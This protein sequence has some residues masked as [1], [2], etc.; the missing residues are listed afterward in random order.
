MDIPK[1]SVIVPIYNVE[2]YL[3]KCVNSILNQ[4]LKEIEVILVDDGS[5]DECPQLCDRFATTDCRIQVIHKRNILEIANVS[6]RLVPYG[7][8]R[9]DFKNDIKYNAVV[10][11]L[12]IEIEK[13]K[14]FLY[15]AIG[16]CK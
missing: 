8:N 11:T 13:S 5:P 4:T 2:K 16:N 14:V 10:D 15:K 1:V 7:T 12:N 6:D 3:K 9:I